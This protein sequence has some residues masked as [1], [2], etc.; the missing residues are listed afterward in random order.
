MCGMSWA[1]GPVWLQRMWPRTPRL[2]AVCRAVLSLHAWHP[3][4]FREVFKAGFA[5]RNYGGA[6]SLLQS[7]VT[8]VQVCPVD[9]ICCNMLPSQYNTFQSQ[10][11][12]GVVV[13]T[14]TGEQACAMGYARCAEKENEL[15]AILSVN[16]LGSMLSEGD[17]CLQ[18][19]A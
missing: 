2:P 1:W 14:V 8:S 9:P 4:L 12:Q 6:L 15:H 3:F 5:I 18:T 16:V 7:V 10:L 13:P 17:G 19:S 11:G